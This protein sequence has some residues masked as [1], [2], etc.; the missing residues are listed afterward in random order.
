MNKIEEQQLLEE[1]IDL[2]EIVPVEEFVAETEIA[3]EIPIEQISAITNYQETIEKQKQTIDEIKEDIRELKQKPLVRTYLIILAAITVLSLVLMFYFMMGKKDAT[4][5]FF[6]VIFGFLALLACAAGII[7]GYKFL[8]IQRILEKIQKPISETAAMNHQEKADGLALFEEIKHQLNS[9]TLLATIIGQDVK[10]MVK[11]FKTL[12]CVSYEDKIR[13]IELQQHLEMLNVQLDKE[14][15]QNER[16]QEEIVHVTTT[17]QS[18]YDELNQL[19]EQI[20]SVPALK[21]DFHIALDKYNNLGGEKAEQAL[22]QEWNTKIDETNYALSIL[23]NEKSVLGGKIEAL[24]SESEQS[25]HYFQKATAELMKKKVRCEQDRQNLL[26]KI[27]HAQKDFESANRNIVETNQKAREITN[28]INTTQDEMERQQLIKERGDIETLLRKHINISEKAKTFI[29]TTSITDI[30]LNI[31][32]LSKDIISIE[33]QAQE[34]NNSIS[35]EIR[36][37]QSEFNHKCREEEQ[38]KEVLNIR[39]GQRKEALRPFL[40]QVETMINLNNKIREILERKRE[41]KPALEAKIIGIT[42]RLD[43]LTVEKA[44]IEMRISDDLKRQG[45]VLDEVNNLANNFID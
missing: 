14:V 16:L 1:T 24:K 10:R 12:R 37:S 15:D 17:Q 11:K 26:K 30:D 44:T 4:A 20:Q 22:T 41:D 25:E 8:K 32:Q 38:L 43:N 5:V 34:K 7:E 13:I 29:D 28:R 39:Q 45:L 35:E 40:E 42:N 9:I 3:T 31:T 18:Y 27:D 19:N 2:A 33:K 36:R 23:E 21:N 6:G